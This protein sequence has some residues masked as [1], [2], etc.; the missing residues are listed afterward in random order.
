VVSF[1]ERVSA[2]F[3]R[4]EERNGTINALLTVRDR[5]EV[6]AEAKRI[7]ERIA[8]GSAGKLAG[9]TIAVKANI[10]VQGLPASCASRTLENYRA[11]YDADVIERI[12]CEDGLIIGMANCD[13]FAA[14]SSGLHSAFGPTRNPIDETRIPGG[15]SSG[16]AAS[17]AAGFSD[18][19]LGTD[20]GGSVRN[21][22]SHCGVVAIKPSYGRVS[23]HGIVDL[24]MSLD[25]VGPIA[26]DVD[27][28][29]R[30]L[31]VIAGSSENDATTIESPV[32]DLV[33]DR[34]VRFAILD[35]SGIEVDPRVLAAFDEAIGAL[36][37]AVGP[38][39]RVSIPQ[40]PL[41]VATY[42]PIV[43]TE[44]YS[45]TRRFDGRR[46]G[47]MIDEVSGE[48]VKRRIRAGARITHAEDEHRFYRKALSVKASIT[49]SF[50]R[51]FETVDVI[52]SPVV[53][54]IAR[55]IDASGVS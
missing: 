25:Q 40:I 52:L 22:A 45:A 21:P 37:R 35:V 47:S 24:S 7:E 51:A 6:I 12:R 14:G 28:A 44:F 32:P 33:I 27:T 30:V 34:P 2:Q 16:S 41:S 29:L 54:V 17:V 31:S 49:A 3:D 26:R 8:S 13:E 23:R 10:N 43:Y 9:L 36:E 46:Y 5:S 4:I 42:Y 19:A 1:V 15:S 39:E 18:A 55:R 48:E 20:T 11:T 50:E 53:P 38:M